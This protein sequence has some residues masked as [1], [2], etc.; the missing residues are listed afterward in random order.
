MEF[1]VLGPMRAR[2]DERD[3]P[4]GGPKQRALLAMLLLHAN[5]A[6][7][8]ER[9]IEGLWGERP[10]PTAEHTLD[11]YVSRLR[12]VLGGGRVERRSPGYVLHVDAGELDVQRFEQLATR[13]RN[14]LAHGRAPDAAVTLND[15]LA[16][17]RG[18]ALADVLYEPFAALDAA[19]L[20]EL[21]LAVLEDRIEADLALG[22]A[23]DV[24]P[25]LERLRR[26]NPFRERPLSLLMLALYRA[27][28]QTEALSV[29]QTS[30]ARLA[31]ELGLDP[32][33]Q[34]QELQRKIL[35]HDAS[36]DP[37]RVGRSIARARP[38]RRLRRGVV[39]G[40][41]ATVVASAAVGIV[42][43]TRGG[44][45]SSTDL[46]SSAIVGLRVGA[47]APGPNV[48]I[49]NAPAAIVA[50]G[51]SL[52]S[53]DPDTGA[54]SRI[55]LVSRSVAD[56]VPVG[57]TPGT[58]AAGGGSVWSASVPGDHVTRIDPDTG[59]VTQTVPLGGAQ[60][61]ALAFGAGGLWV[62]DLV[63]NSLIELAPSSGAARRTL[64]VHVRPTTLAIAAGRV[65]VAGYRDA[66]VEELDLATGQSVATIRVG[67]G[68][69]AV[70]VG[71]GAVW[72]ANSL[73]ST[74]SRID[75]ATDSVAAVIPVG[76]GPTSIALAGGSVWV[77][78]QY[79]SSVSRIDPTRDTLAG[80]SSVQG[81]P[82]ALATA[83]GTLFAG[84]GPLTQHRGGTLVL[85]H[86]RPISI[87]PALNVDLMPTVSD[88]LT[89]DALV[90]YNHVGGPAGI[91][92]VP[93]LA[94]SIPV[95]TDNGT[96]Y[97]FRLRPHIRYSDGRLLRAADF[98]RGVERLFRVG[99]DGRA[100]FDGIAGA[101]RCRP[102]SC[103]LSS[104]IVTDDA[105]RTVTYHLRAADPDFL[106]NLASHG[107]GIPVPPG[108]PFHDT[109][110]VPI[111][112]T[113][114]YLIASA[115]AHEVRYVR[116]RFF[117][118]WS[119]AAQ[120][121][122]NPDEIDLRFG[123]SQAEEVRAVERSRADWLGDNVTAQVLPTLRRK[124]ASRLH[125]FSIPTTDF[126]QLNTTLPPFNDVRARRALNFALDR[127]RI[128]RI[129]GGSELATPTCQILPPGVVGFRRYCPYTLHPNGAGVW[130][131]P[132]LVRARRL[133]A[134]SGTRGTPVTVWGWTDDPTISP[135]VVTYVAGELRRLGF[136]TSVRLIPHA[137]IDNLAVAVRRT[138]QLIPAGWGDTPFGFFET[139]FA[140][141]GATTHGYFCD[142]RVDAAIKHA[143]ALK[144]TNPRA[145][146]M[147][148]AEL[149]RQLVDLA[150]WAPMIDEHAID[151]VS[152]R[153]RNYQ[154]HPYWGII[155]DQLWID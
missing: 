78:N 128:E 19:R 59:A 45:A 8:R 33:P 38:R 73:D 136:G 20:E 64:R 97:T 39:A 4:L 141:G 31:E 143:Q 153:V 50:T 70:A 58:L 25:E 111:P 13:G 122:G 115:N 146:A 24:L 49:P 34:L 27:G 57:G 14:E 43:G 75:P 9:L 18:A 3:L 80:T 152:A 134:A 117:H 96:T 114:P 86:T 71:L 62:A 99:S 77:A 138:V 145:A 148:W 108:T 79:S 55:D 88:G 155:A 140:C 90:T 66:E 93:D 42:L 22:R 35:A 85:L 87:D 44:K 1:G 68:P 15:A 144:A 98:R 112:G 2:R 124:Y 131:A 154:A 32:G 129:Y 11:N 74:V 56:R 23:R 84:V 89:S 30:R 119:H 21:R 67:N 17:W 94:V 105:A 83:R 100:L 37:P 47:A 147:A 60:V 133:V 65:W 53:A 91:Q 29:F 104:G 120:P 102:P 125:G 92:L 126:F 46:N 28:R 139:L 137:G 72:V 12:Q 7:A 36:L 41:A 149:D 40:V 63:D 150:A 130:T 121:D 110:L 10:P 81:R 54:V 26:E 113:G 103:D 76:S 151:F 48:T 6:V 16:L 142:P 61:S 106:D 101:E 109:G 118:E 127:G 52:W 69:T 132:D 107:L 5:E 116:N 82:T 95:P 135:R 51:E 123:L